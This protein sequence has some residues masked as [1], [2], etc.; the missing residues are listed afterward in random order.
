MQ[1]VFYNLNSQ[2]FLNE[3]LSGGWTIG[4]IAKR[5]HTRGLQKRNI[6][7]STVSDVVSLIRDHIQ[8]ETEKFKKFIIEEVEPCQRPTKNEKKV[9]IS[10]AGI[11]KCLSIFFSFEWQNNWSTSVMSSVHS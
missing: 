1:A 10:L 11:S 8:P 3:L 7:V 5:A 4:S 6:G 9:G 2:V